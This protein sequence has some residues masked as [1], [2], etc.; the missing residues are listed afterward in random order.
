M[1]IHTIANTVFAVM[2]RPVLREGNEKR[3]KWDNPSFPGVQEKDPNANVQAES[4]RF[5]G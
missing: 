1:N 4:N 2:H 5:R 3:A